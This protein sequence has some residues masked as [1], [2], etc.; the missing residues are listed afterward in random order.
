MTNWK[1]V[2][3]HL[4]RFGEIVDKQSWEYEIEVIAFCENTMRK[5]VQ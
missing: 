3:P 4:E 2:L 1:Q 5:G